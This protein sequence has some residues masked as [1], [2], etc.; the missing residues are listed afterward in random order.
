MNDMMSFAMYRACIYFGGSDKTFN[1][2][3]LSKAIT[4]IAGVKTQ[5]DGR[6]LRALL[7]GRNDVEMLSGGCHYRMVFPE[8]EV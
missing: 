1:L 3:G 2:A 5:I 6:I 7:V 8:G 4:K